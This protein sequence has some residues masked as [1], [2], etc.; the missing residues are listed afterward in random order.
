MA[1]TL[2]LVYDDI[3]KETDLAYLFAFGDYQ[4]WIPK[5]VIK[6]MDEKESILTL[7][8]WF[9]EKNGLEPYIY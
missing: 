8:D 5:S 3:L 4:H 6:E 7:P 1:L 9:I 2:D